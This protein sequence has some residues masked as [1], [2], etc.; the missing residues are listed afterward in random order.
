MIAEAIGAF[1]RALELDPEMRVAQDNLETVQRESGYYDTIIGDLREQLA[2]N[3]NARDARLELARAYVALGQQDQAAEQYEELLRSD[4]ADATALIKLGLVEQSRGRQELAT[5]WFQR[6]C[7]VDPKSSVAR[8][9]LGRALYN[10]GLND[11]A[12]TILTEAVALN[13]DH[14]EV[15]YI[16]GFLYGDLGHH[17]AARSATRRAI[18]LNPS[19]GTAQPNLL[20]GAQR[21]AAPRRPGGRKPGAR[22]DREPAS[23]QPHLSLSVAFRKRGYLTEALRECRL[24]LESGEDEAT[25]LEA[26]AET[27]LLRKDF[28]AAIEFYDRLLERQPGNAE[29]WNER[30]VCLH[31]AG[32]REEARGSYRKAVD[33]DP[34]YALAW[35]NLGVAG[36]SDADTDAAL[37]ALQAALRARPI[38]RRPA[39]PRPAPSAAPGAEAIARGLSQPADRTL[40]G[41]RGLERHRA[42][43]DGAAPSPG[44]P[45]R[46]CPLG[47]GR[48]QQ[49]LGALQPGVRSQSARRLRRRAAGNPPGPGAG[50][51]LRAGILRA[52]ES[53]SS[54]K[55]PCFRCPRRS[56]R[57][58]A[59][60]PRPRASP[61]IR[62]CSTDFSV[63][64]LPSPTEPEPTALRDDPYLLTRDLIGKGLLDTAAAEVH[65]ALQRGA[66]P[67][68]GAALLGDIFAKR[69]LFGEAL[70]RYREAAALAPEDVEI[71]Q[72]ETAALVA[73]GRGPDA[74]AVASG[75][76][77]SHPTAPTPW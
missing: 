16:L 13:P 9:C 8:L 49:R 5:E 23:L 12:L 76:R 3:P 18:A 43:A 75:S 67:A 68:T 53:S 29:L 77:P 39:Q 21:G 41:S 62:R 51:V 45:Q 50:P 26:M 10:R 44:R 7:E 47:G 27:H 71:L 65:R 46:L 1:S 74:I 66:P 4:P 36:S 22:G 30:G 2:R 72:G 61:S 69:G 40:D 14:A 64:S 73:L 38:S 56:P 33:A 48:R 35:N 42:G 11:K 25:A 52:G 57:C 37:E 54:S 31:Q 55:S 34:T 15:H 20:I 28:G 63:S 17:D 58:R 32:R 24:A 19:L 59:R 60:W 6:A 70:E